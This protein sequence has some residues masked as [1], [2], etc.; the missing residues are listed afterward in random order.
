MKAEQQPQRH[1]AQPPVEEHE[2]G[3]QVEQHTAPGHDV[4]RDLAGPERTE[5]EHLR[6]PREPHF[7]R[8]GVQQPV[9]VDFGDAPEKIHAAHE[10]GEEVDAPGGRDGRPQTGVPPYVQAPF[11]VRRRQAEQPRQPAKQVGVVEVMRLFKQE[12]IGEECRENRSRHAEPP[13]Q[14]HADAEAETGEEKE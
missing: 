2:T 13:P 7:Q 12:K 3:R 8:H 5:Q 6:P 1:P 10:R 14:G 4:S 11:P 9:R